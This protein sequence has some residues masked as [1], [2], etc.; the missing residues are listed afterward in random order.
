MAW[1]ATKSAQVS[2]ALS[3]TQNR[4]RA[5]ERSSAAL[6]EL[7]R[8]RVGDHGVLNLIEALENI[9]A[10]PAALLE[11][12]TVSGGSHSGVPKRD[13]APSGMSGLR[14]GDSGYFFDDPPI[15]RS[16]NQTD[17][18]EA[19]K[20]NSSKKSG[21]YTHATANFPAQRFQTDFSFAVDNALYN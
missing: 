15:Q 13:L 7:L 18:I 16:R 10:G 14:Y 21:N 20:S 11:A 1:E 12:A 17:L 3:A 19:N 5:V 6:R 2:L 4:L 8:Q 9:G